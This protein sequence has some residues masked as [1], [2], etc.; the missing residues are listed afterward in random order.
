MLQPTSFA[1]TRFY[2]Y[3]KITVRS[4]VDGVAFV[5]YFPV[6]RPVFEVTFGFRN[7]QESCL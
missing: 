1:Y 6:V 4:A 3:A 7:R 5:R 2:F